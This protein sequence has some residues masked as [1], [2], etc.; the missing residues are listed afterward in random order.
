[1]AFQD[2]INK[3]VVPYQILNSTSI[4]IND[5]FLKKIQ[6]LLEKNFLEFKTDVS[7]QAGLTFS[8]PSMLFQ[9]S[10][11]N[12]TKVYES[13]TISVSETEEDGSV[14]WPLLLV[15]KQTKKDLLMKIH[16]FIQQSFQCNLRP[17]QLTEHHMIWLIGIAVNETLK[18]NINSGLSLT[19]NLPTKNAAEIDIYFDDDLLLA[20]WDSTHDSLN[21][22]IKFEEIKVLFNQM[23]SHINN[24]Y[25]IDVSQLNVNSLL[26]KC[27]HLQFHEQF[28]MNAAKPDMIYLLLS[29]VISD[30][31][32]SD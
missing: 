20:L 9:V 16:Q 25:G 27:L 13:M 17:V 28:Q 24:V 5:S 23:V 30:C 32:E 4:A 29:F 26:L 22:I 8:C 21:D 11:K 18:R 31:L 2:L 6:T 15:L 12:G 7:L 14:T 3:K 19:F 1:M 10:L